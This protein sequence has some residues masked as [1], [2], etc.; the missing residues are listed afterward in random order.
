MKAKQSKNPNE[1]TR[2]GQLNARY[3]AIAVLKAKPGQAQRL[4]DFAL[5]VLPRIRKVKGLHKVEVNRSTTDP[6]R[7]VL[8]Y[9]WEKAGDSDR[10]VAGPVYASIAPRLA[11]LVEEHE[12]YM[13]EN[14]G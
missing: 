6:E 3:R 9:W 1:Q 8:Y 11:S 10:Y 14:L 7:L 5:E 2:K 13:T 4:L 12:L